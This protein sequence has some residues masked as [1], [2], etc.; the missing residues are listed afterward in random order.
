MKT[1]LGFLFKLPL[2]DKF[3]GTLVRHSSNGVGWVLTFIGLNPVLVSE[4]LGL[5]QTRSVIAGVVMIA[6][7]AL[8]SLIPVKRTS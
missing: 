6:L 4:W 5:S 7:S 8:A 1:I 3:I 2:S